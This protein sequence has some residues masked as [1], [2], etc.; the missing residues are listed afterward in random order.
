MNSWSIFKKIK[1]R[2]IWKPCDRTSRV[3]PRELSFRY[4]VSFVNQSLGRVKRRASH[5]S[6]RMLSL[7]RGNKGFFSFA[8][9][10][11]HV[12]YAY[13]PGLREFEN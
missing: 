3:K 13:D 11:A 5:E 12:K 4:V 9:D 10:S 2:R 1:S 7:M 6:N 8:F